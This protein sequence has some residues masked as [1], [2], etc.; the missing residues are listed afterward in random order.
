M[1]NT[2]GDDNTAFGSKAL[3]TN[4]TGEVNVAIGR[5]SLELNTTGTANTAAGYDALQANTTGSYNVALGYGPLDKNTTGTRN[6]AVGNNA[7]DAADT[8]ND[9]LAIGYDALGGAIAGGEFNV[10][11]GNYSLDATTSGDNNT[12]TGYDALTGTTTGADNTALGSDAGDVITT[13]SQNVIIGSDS[14]PSANSAT[15]Q[16]VIGYGA[17]GHGNN[18]VV[19]GNGSATNWEPHD[20]NEV[21]LGH[22]SYRFDDVYA[23][24]GTVQTSDVR[25]KKQIKESDLGLDFINELNPVSYHW[26][27]NDNGRHYGL[28]AQEL[29]AVFQ[30]HGIQS[31][32]EIATVDWDEE[33]D[34]Y[35]L[36][37]AELI[38]PMIKALQEL[39]VKVEKLENQ[40]EANG[41]DVSASQ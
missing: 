27:K 19:I 10:A 16:I 21:D 13:G 7:L 1:S 3:T 2:T 35:G 23:T 22:S 31:V 5:S 29:L 8:E 17:T 15:N 4:T 26:K 28:I 18:R 30:R 24:N 11:I 25:L 32:D 40:L 9:N 39:S 38:S 6:I 34:R 41:I 14:D 20:D 36:H 12:A 33:S 37:Y